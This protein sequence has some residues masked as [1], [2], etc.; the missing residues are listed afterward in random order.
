MRKPNKKKRFKLIKR[1]PKQFSKGGVILQPSG[2]EWLYNKLVDSA[3]K[4][5]PPFISKE[6]IDKAK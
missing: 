4:S 6:R 3:P 5:L 1:K 2:I